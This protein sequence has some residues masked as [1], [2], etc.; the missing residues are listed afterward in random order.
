ME[1]QLYTRV[2][3]THF[4]CFLLDWYVCVCGACSAQT[5]TKTEYPSLG[6]ILI[7]EWNEERIARKIYLL[8]TTEKAKLN[9]KL[10]RTKFI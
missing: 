3:M 4:I 5:F 2:L 8:V 7:N 1:V 9:A 6:M 10:Y